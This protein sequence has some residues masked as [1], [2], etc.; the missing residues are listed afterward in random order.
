MACAGRTFH[1]SVCTEHFSL[2]LHCRS[3]SSSTCR[4]WQQTERT[5][6]N[7]PRMSVIV[8]PAREMVGGLV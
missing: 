6:T 1:S 4:G 2:R 7:D 8:P 3:S 5:K